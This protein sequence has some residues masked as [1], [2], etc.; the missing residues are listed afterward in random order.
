MDA[1]A[2]KTLARPVAARWAVNTLFL[3]CGIGYGVWATQIPRI[4]ENLNLTEGQLSIALLFF[5]LG[6]IL[7]M[8]LTGWATARLG[9]RP[10]AIAG[11]LAFA[12]ALGLIGFAPD[13]PW[14][15]VLAMFAGATSGAMDVSMNTHGTAVE[16]VWGAAIMSSFHGFFSLGGFAGA[17]AGG[18][19][20]KAGL[21]VAGVLLASG[22]VS[23]VL[24][25]AAIPFLRFD[26]ETVEG[27]H[28]FAWPTTAVL[29]IGALAFLAFMMEGAVADW[30]G[31]YLREGTG[32]SFA[33]AGA[34]YGA[35][36]F[37]MMA[38]RFAGD[39][40]VRRFGR[41]PVVAVGGALAALGFLLSVATPSPVLAA[42]GFGLVG[43]G[44][45]NAAPV[46]FSAAGETSGLT[47]GVGVAMAATMGYA[48]FLLGPPLIG[49]TA[50][51]IGLRS[52]LALLAVGALCIALFAK[53]AVP[54]SR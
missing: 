21:S 36:S 24:V 18:L 34:G 43:L 51:F 15:I 54:A 2:A 13:L 39:G 49:L 7:V 19:L 3:V 5:A 14:L 30:S 6:A 11:S 32:A 8:P 40:I 33:V 48:G 20:I 47:P 9:S 16:R 46:F 17:A 29:G 28:G 42:I 26:G 50:G 12:V 27:G 4:K 22:I 1:S 31:V 41:V 38:C 35:F 10:A 52:A 25:F 45:A 37:A 23:A 44:L 53:A